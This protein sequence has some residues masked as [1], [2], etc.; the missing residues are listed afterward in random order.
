M[1]Y[2]RLVGLRNEINFNIRVASAPVMFQN[3]VIPVNKAGIL[4]IKIVTGRAVA[5]YVT[6]ETSFEFYIKVSSSSQSESDW[7]PWRKVKL[8]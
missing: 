3:G 1:D 6:D 4:F 2:V 7:K 5:K 8:S